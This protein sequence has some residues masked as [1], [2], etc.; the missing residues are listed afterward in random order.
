M[1][2]VQKAIVTTIN[3]KDGLHAR[4]VTSFIYLVNGFHDTEFVIEANGRSINGKSLL[5]V[6]SLGICEGATIQITVTGPATE[7]ECSID[8]IQRLI[9]SNFSEATFK[10]LCKE[11]HIQNSI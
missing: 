7:V 11:Y 9:D 8:A 10:E 4:P 5:G 3:H 1:K 6:I 2:K